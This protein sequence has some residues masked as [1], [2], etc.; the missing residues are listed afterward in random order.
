VN[1]PIFDLKI[2]LVAMAT[3]LQLSHR[4]KRSNRQST[5]NT[6]HMVNIWWKSVPKMLRSLCSNVY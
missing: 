4:K 3:S 6:Y 5:I 2:S 1:S